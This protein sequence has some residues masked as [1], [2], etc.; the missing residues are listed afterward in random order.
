MAITSNPNY[1]STKNNLCRT[2]P[3]WNWIVYA[4]AYLPDFNAG[5]NRLLYV[6]LITLGISLLAGVIV[7][8]WFSRK[9]TKPILQVADQAKL[10]AHGNYTEGSIEITSKDEIGELVR[11]QYH[12]KKPKKGRGSDP[13]KCRVSSSVTTYMGEGIIVIDR[14]DRLTFMNPEAER[15]FGW[16]EEECLNQNLY[17]IIH[18]SEDGPFSI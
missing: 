3:S 16:V 15:F 11:F 14:K 12:E 4:G 17:D 10:I 18:R 9:L 7:I 13:E 1:K 2:R 8:L 5:A 6:L